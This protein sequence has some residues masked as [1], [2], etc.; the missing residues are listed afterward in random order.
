[1]VEKIVFDYLKDK[2]NTYMERPTKPPK[3]YII[4]EK[5]NGGVENMTEYATITIQSYATTLFNAAKLNEDVCDEMDMIVNETDVMRCSL[6]AN[7]N[8]TDAST[9]E[10]RYQAMILSILVDTFI[11]KISLPMQPVPEIR[12]ISGA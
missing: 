11:S 5:T 6:N 2:F 12:S 1:M 9:K 7:Y 8:Y 3:E 10:Y 4:I